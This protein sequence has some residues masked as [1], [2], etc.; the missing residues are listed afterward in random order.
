KDITIEEALTACE[1]IKKS[2]I[3]LQAFFIAG[4][5]QETE[6]SL[7]R[8][9]TAMK[10]VKCSLLVFNTFTPYPG[11][12]AFELCRKEGMIEDDY[13][14]S[15]YNHHSPD[16]YYCSNIER[17][18]FR[19]LISEIRKTVD[20][21]NKINRIKK[22]FSGSTFRRIQELGIGKSLSKCRKVFIGR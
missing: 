10:K 2:G 16:N 13:D 12:E 20:R 5:P 1:I 8:T 7:S 21:K 15:L 17:E 9:V 18:K 19:I 4:F 22:I 14:V 11:T 6:S 3:E